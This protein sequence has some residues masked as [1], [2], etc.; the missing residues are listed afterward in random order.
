MVLWRGISLIGLG[1]F[2][3]MVGLPLLSW[4]NS[5]SPWA[6]I[7]A[8]GA[9]NLLECALGSKTSGLLAEWQLP[10]VF[11]AEDAAERAAAEPDLW[12]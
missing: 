9:G 1:V 2:C 4:V 7:P 11:D 8:E 3:G 5:V 12:D 6:E 10:D